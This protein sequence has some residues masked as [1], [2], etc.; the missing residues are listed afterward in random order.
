MSDVGRK[1]AEAEIVPSIL[2]EPPKEKLNVCFYKN[3]FFLFLSNY[4]WF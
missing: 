4:I 2:P 3:I 1:F